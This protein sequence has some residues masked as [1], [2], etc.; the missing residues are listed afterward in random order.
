MCL[1]YVCSAQMEFEDYVGLYQKNEVD[2]ILDFLKRGERS[3]QI[4]S[5]YDDIILLTGNTGTGKSTLGR[6]VA[7]NLS[8]LE[9]IGEGPYRIKYKD[10]GII[11]NSTT[12]SQ[13][14]YPERIIDETD[15]AFYDCP[16][17]DDTRNSSVEITTTYLMKKVVDNAKSLKIILVANYDSVLQGG[18]RGDF[19]TL[20]EHTRR[21]LKN[22]TS[23]EDSIALIATKVNNVY[24][25]VNKNLVLR[26]DAEMIKGIVAFLSEYLDRLKSETESDFN[27][28]ARALVEILLKSADNGKTYEK[29]GIFRQPDEAGPLDQIELMVEGREKARDLIINRITYGVK[30]AS[31]IGYTISE[32]SRLKLIEFATGFNTEITKKVQEVGREIEEHFGDEEKR[33]GNLVALANR[34]QNAYYS[35]SNITENVNLNGPQ[36]INHLIDTVSELRVPVSPEYFAK[37]SSYLH[38]INFL[39]E[40]T[41]DFLPISTNDW[42]TGLRRCK[43]YLE[44]TKNWFKFLS[45]IYDQYSQYDFRSEIT[46][47][48][49]SDINDWGMNGKPQGIYIG[50]DRT[51]R[52]FAEK[53]K[54]P[55]L[56][57]NVKMTAFRLE[58]LN[59]LSDI[60]LKQ[61]PMSTCE[62]DNTKLIVKGDFVRMIDVDK[63]LCGDKLKTLHIFALNTVFIDNDLHASGNKLN[64]T[65]IA[66]KWHISGDNRK[67]NLSG[68]DN[69]Y[70]YE[71]AAEKS[72]RANKTGNPGL[73]G[74]AGENSGNFIGLGL[75]FIQGSKLEI[76]GECRFLVELILCIDR[77]PEQHDNVCE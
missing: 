19:V 32:A 14:I 51:F 5:N 11:G 62:A 4:D 24:V 15:V 65:I 22:I 1:V 52:I 75:H 66:P 46:K 61:T 27:I 38:H 41:I 54:S 28:Y 48:N 68:L 16:G 3:L 50:D 71:S 59:N 47:Y 70:S 49:V 55:E 13:T 25:K 76:Y 18:S 40:F 37:I 74:K 35:I 26:S 56:V 6:F 21:F 58:V 60:T 2:E 33:M 39:Q 17:Y 45:E 9:S 73:A 29:I 10:E 7:G 53:Q 57:R 72:I 12:V 69:G 42:S 63:T 64:I 77:Y 20:I 23:Y 67:F 8:D 44:E 34:Y 36:Y 30:N 43:D 31:E